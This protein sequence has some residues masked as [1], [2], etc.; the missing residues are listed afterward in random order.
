M[1]VICCPWL[2]EGLF[3]C[4]CLSGI[5]IIL[6]LLNVENIVLKSTLFDMSCKKLIYDR[7]NYSIK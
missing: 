4:R 6:I 3:C 5:L 7:L 1:M 2:P